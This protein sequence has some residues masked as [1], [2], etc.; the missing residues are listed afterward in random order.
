MKFKSKFGNLAM[1]DF[2]DEEV[3]DKADPTAGVDVPEDDAETPPEGTD[4]PPAAGET[5]DPAAEPAAGDDA[6]PDAGNSGTDNADASDG[7]G[8]PDDAAATDEPPVEN[9]P[10]NADADAAVSDVNNTEDAPDAEGGELVD[11]EAETVETELSEADD[12]GDDME[13]TSDD[14]ENLDIAA[15]SLEN[16]IAGLES[17]METGGL[18][19]SGA[20]IARNNLNTVTR[21]LKVNSLV[22][23]ALEDMESPSAKINAASTMK[24]SIVKFVQNIIKAIKDAAMR[25]ADWIVQT[26]KRL[27]NANVAMQ[28]R[29]EKLLERVKASEMKTGN[30]DNAKL[31]AALVAESKPVTDLATFASGMAKAVQFM[32]NPSTYKGY[33]DALAQ[34]EEM[35]KE[36]AREEE[37]RGKISETLNKWSEDFEKHAV[38]I[39]GYAR[40]SGAKGI[41]AKVV[42]N[43]K[44]FGIPLLNNEAVYVTLP[45]T[46]EGIG[47]LNAITQQLEGA[48]AVT[49]VTA[50]DK[51]EATK[52]CEL[53]I[54]I[55]KD[56][57]KS[58]EDNRGGVKELIAAIDK[59]KTTTLTMLDHLVNGK[60]ESD[61]PVR[62]ASIFVAKM[63]TSSARLPVHALNR[64]VPRSMGAILDLVAASLGDA[65]K[66]NALK[67]DANASKKI[68]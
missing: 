56:A 27:T 12:I 46:A 18:D 57:Q 11:P 62:K 13:E 39:T 41:G 32:N 47:L 60:E 61:H 1:E 45:D 54:S 65:S 26:Y 38:N 20:I 36:P 5:P 17:A 58:A 51:A 68:K 19:Y 53:I 35:L 37:V 9:N 64:A 8:D 6:N 50:L 44:M 48:P 14:V 10:E 40:S 23:P 7:S 55:A 67:P 31:A 42:E 2:K 4:A 22:V 30:I 52:L 24:D 28:A 29:A 49:S 21:F 25:F 59:Q 66:E 15:E 63:L 34:C 33:L 3:T 16:L 43:T